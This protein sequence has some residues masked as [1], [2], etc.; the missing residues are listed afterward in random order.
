LARELCDTEVLWF[1]GEEIE[2]L[3]SR[4]HDGVRLDCGASLSSPRP[5]IRIE[6]TGPRWSIRTL[7]CVLLCLALAG[8]GWSRFER[9]RA[10]L[11][12]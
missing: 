6:R 1:A 12:G 8:V 10:L 3:L 9:R 2:Q 5:L 7:L 4:P 11:S